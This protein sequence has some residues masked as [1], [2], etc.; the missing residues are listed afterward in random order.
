MNSSYKNTINYGE[1]IE[2]LTYAVQPKT[3]VEIGILDGYSLEYLIKG[4]SNMN[5]VII[6][7][8]DIFEEFNG[9][10][11]N[12][13]ALQLKFSKYNNVSI[14]Y[15]DFYEIHKLLSDNSVDIIHIDI[16]NNGNV[17][18]FAMQNYFPKLSKKGMMIF[19]GG[20][21]KRDNVE[22]MLKYDKSKIQPV[23]EKYNMKVIGDFPS[24]SIIKKT[25]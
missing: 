8:Y 7:A 6:N 24:L 10:H 3:I 14:K 2:G 20:S 25:Y 12:N 23:V 5:N 21:E 17:Y 11:A 13:D 1:L 15:G 9:N 4:C 22:W 19:E 16:A 18:E